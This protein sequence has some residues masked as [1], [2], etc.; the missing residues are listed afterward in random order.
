[1]N[2]R[3]QIARNK[4][5]SWFLMFT[6][7][8]A[9]LVLGFVIGLAYWGDYYGGLGLLGVFGVVAIIWSIIAYYA[10]AG[11]ALAVSGAKEVTHDQEPQLWNIVEEMSIASGLPMPRVFVIESDAANAFATGRDPKH[12]AVAVTRGLMHRLN[13]EELQ[14]VIAHEMSHIRNYDIRFATLV[15]I[16]VGL[17]ALVADF[18]LRSMFFAGGGRRSGGGGS[19]GGNVIFLIIAIAMAILAPLF[20]YMVQFA[21]SRK[22][23]Y[24]ADASGVEL[25]RNPKGLES[26]LRKIAADPV[27]LKSANR[28]TAHLFIANPLKK[29][30]DKRKA[31]LFDTH[32]P[33]QERIDRLRKMA[34]EGPLDEDAAAAATGAAAVSGGPA[35][36]AVDGTPLS[37]GTPVEP[38]RQPLPDPR[39]LPRPLDKS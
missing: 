32:P 25:T 35:D 9:L 29:R 7:V 8:V 4:R 3:Q 22:R 23:E 38:P 19:G 12:S 30:K 31:G 13:R 34:F 26:A 15:G 1:M 11:M 37:G 2:F 28:A 20:A 36:V 10:G 16:L 33:I 17:I 5:A 39:E 6:I 14:G 21:V 24:L 27:E 18:F